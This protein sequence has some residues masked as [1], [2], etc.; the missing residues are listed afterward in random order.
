[1]ATFLVTQ[2]TGYQSRWT[3]THLLEAGAKVHAVVRNAQKI[4]PLLQNPAVTVFQGES[5]EFESISRAAQGCQAVFL[6]TF[7]IPGLETQQAQTVVDACKSAG[8][9]GIVLATTFCTGYRTIW[10]DTATKDCQLHDYYTSKAAIEDIVRRAGFEAYTILR[11]AFIHFDYL[12]PHS[13]FN[14]PRLA[15]DGELDHFYNDNARMPQTDAH[16]VG[17]YAAAAL[18]NPAKFR[19]Q[20]I[21][22]ANENLTINEVCEILARVS[23]KDVRVKKHASEGIEA[24]KITVMAQRF[25]QWANVKDFSTAVEAAKEAQVKFGITFTPLEKALRRERDS[26]LES[27]PTQL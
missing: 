22:L 7:P 6:N 19:N 27:L 14:F 23:G 16:D 17:K 24:A 13:Q 3:I 2:A 20:E 26:L 4:P 11:P 9:K 5:N 18:Q 10:D 1:M 21:E 12:L 25:H 15:S 8:L